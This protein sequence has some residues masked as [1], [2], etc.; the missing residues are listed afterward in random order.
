MIAPATGGIPAAVCRTLCQGAR[1]A[2]RGRE[3]GTGVSIPSEREK[4]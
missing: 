2:G 3:K 4:E 1:M